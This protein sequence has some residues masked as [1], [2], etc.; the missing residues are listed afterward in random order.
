[1]QRRLTCI[2]LRLTIFSFQS[3]PLILNF[4][5]QHQQPVLRKLSVRGDDVPL[6]AFSPPSAGAARLF[7]GFGAAAGFAVI[8]SSWSTTLLSLRPPAAVGTRVARLMSLKMDRLA[9]PF[10]AGFLYFLA[11]SKISS[12]SQRA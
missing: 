9:G 1:M 11:A 4:E 7:L 5:P 10:L 12:A 8:S 2:Q 6:V 3:L